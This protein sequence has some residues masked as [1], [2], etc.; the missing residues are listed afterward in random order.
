MLPLLLSDLVLVLAIGFPFGPIL[1][2]LLFLES[3]LDLLIYFFLERI[4]VGWL[5]VRIRLSLIIPAKYLENAIQK[6][7]VGLS[8]HHWLISLLEVLVLQVT[9]TDID[10]QGTAPRDSS[11]CIE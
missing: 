1:R 2:S 3:L 7:R 5:A 9:H 11:R 10:S 8:G 6:L 4:G